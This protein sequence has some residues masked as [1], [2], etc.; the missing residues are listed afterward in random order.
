MS[1]PHGQWALIAKRFSR[2]K[3]AVISLAVVVV[4]Y[5]VALL[6]EVVAPYSANQRDMG[7]INAPPQPVSWTW[8]EGLHTDQVIRT[9]DPV[10]HL[11]TY[12]VRIDQPIPLGFFVTGEPYHLCGLI[13]LQRRLFGVDQVAWQRLYPGEPVPM[14]NLLGADRLGRDLLSRLVFGSRISLSIGLVAIV[15]TF[16]LGITLGGISGYVGGWTDTLLQRVIEVIN[17]FPQLPMWLAI[18][19]LMPE[20]WPPL[21]VYFVITLVLSMLN[22]TGLARVV[23]GKFLSLR[24]ED[25]CT[26]A[27]LVGASHR[28]IIFVHLLPGF[29]S[30]IIVSLTLSIPAMILGETGLSFLGLG[31]RPPVVS[32][33]VLLQDCMDIEAVAQQPWLLAPIGSIILIVMAFNFLGDGL[34][35]A[36]DPYASR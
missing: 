32:W 1:D 25:Y 18:A 6:A 35:D 13:P 17:A 12:Q 23:R 3:L 29:T 15:A 34:R 14:V 19:A 28:R 2:H 11:T 24:E 9:R 7:R 4:M 21:M 36:A 27:R 20:S 22:W 10:T 5:L 8:A 31:L 33:G 30:H 26:A 16:M